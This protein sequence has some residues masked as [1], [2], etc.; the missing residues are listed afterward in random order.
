MIR[1]EVEQTSEDFIGP[2]NKLADNLTPSHHW[3]SNEAFETLVQ[4]CALPTGFFFLKSTKY[5]VIPIG[6]CYVTLNQGLIY[7]HSFYLFAVATF[8]L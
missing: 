8:A 7:L 1:C 4:I 2:G 6:V 3:K 5:D